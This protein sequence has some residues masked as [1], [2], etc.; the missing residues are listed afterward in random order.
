MNYFFVSQRQ[1]YKEEHSQG[2]L[3]APRDGVWHHETMSKV[4]KGDV[5]IQY[6]GKIV[7]IGIALQDNYNFDRPEED[8]FQKWEKQGYKVDIEQIHFITPV[9]KD[10]VKKVLLESQPKDHAPLNLNGGV[11]QGYLF[12]ANEA[13]L[14]VILQNALEID[15][16]P[17]QAEIVKTIQEKLNIDL[18][19]KNS[20]E[21][22]QRQDIMKRSD[23][24]Q[25]IFFG[26]PGTGK[27]YKVNAILG[28]ERKKNF[29][30]SSEIA[31]SNHYAD[32]LSNKEFVDCNIWL[33]DNIGLLEKKLTEF[34]SD[35]KRANPR[36]SALSAYIDFFKKYR[37]ENRELRTTFHPDYDYAQFVGAYKPKKVQNGDDGSLSKEQLAQKLSEIFPTD[38]NG[39]ID[40]TTAITLFGL[41][42]ANSLKEKNMNEIVRLSEIGTDQYKSAYLSAA[43]K[44][45]LQFSNVDEKITYSFVPQV[46][47][48]AY[49]MAWKLQ[50][51]GA[52][53]KSVFLVI[54]EINR[55]NCA[56]I[57]GDIFQLLDR[58]GSGASQYSIDA[59]NDF[60]TWLKEESVLK[61]VWSDYVDKVGEGKLKLP[62]NLNILA[63]MNTSDQS[64]FPM[65]SAFKR[66]FDWEYVPIKYAKDDDCGEN[67]DADGFK[68]VIENSEYKWLDFLEKVN[69]DIYDATRS[70]DKQ[71]GE[72]FIKPK[73]GKTILF[74]DFRS[75]V[76][77]Y[78]WDSVYKDE[79]ERQTVFH[80]A[81][82]NGDDK[83]KSVTFQ[84]LFGK[85]AEGIV[86]E[87]MK[88]L[89]V[90]NV[91]G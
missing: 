60:A 5:I 45:R 8:G 61:D 64:L 29:A 47:A 87:I 39:E 27:S 57:F 1:T 33:I 44:A 48:K 71:M 42:Y 40:K 52:A 83:I 75:K 70:E 24:I 2:Y 6:T 50:L 14:N 20:D 81:Y 59:D 58:D 46:F 89:D 43:V 62:P 41:Q 90:K 19:K 76:L 79:T 7:G 54:E 77:F 12:P 65:D 11:N 13:M 53:D 9:E 84:S 55:G 18:S 82:E 23:S 51:A 30:E 63:T 72:F 22:E 15:Q 66:R 86:N 91:N 73:D 36:H 35:D 3:W 49:A 88:K 21:S 26:A 69:A 80:F 25:K 78:L 38:G 28:V 32:V 4:K 56:Q 10:L 16:S 67:W 34:E 68:I 85:N 31:K 37:E 74:G 17:Q